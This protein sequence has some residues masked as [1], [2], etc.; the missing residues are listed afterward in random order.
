MRCYGDKERTYLKKAPTGLLPAMELDG[1]FMTESKA[2]MLKLED[3]FPDYL[4]LLPKKGTV[5][6]IANR[7]REVQCHPELPGVTSTAE[8]PYS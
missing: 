8:L 5:T 4:P 2:I 6:V 3:A 7:E 1:V